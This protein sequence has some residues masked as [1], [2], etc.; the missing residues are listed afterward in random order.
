[1]KYKKKI[2]LILLS[3]VIITALILITTNYVTIYYKTKSLKSDILINISE[4][5]YDINCK[6]KCNPLE[7]Y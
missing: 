2:R 7:I 5:L 6:S 3:S 1:M 4:D